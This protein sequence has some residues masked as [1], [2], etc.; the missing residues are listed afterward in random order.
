MPFFP[1]PLVRRVGDRLR[2]PTPVPRRFCTEP[3]SLARS[4]YTAGAFHADS[5]SVPQRRALADPVAPIIHS[6]AP[7]TPSKL[8]RL[9]EQIGGHFA[10]L[11]L[12][13]IAVGDWR[14]AEAVG[15]RVAAHATVF[16]LVL[17]SGTV[18]DYD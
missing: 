6:S 10:F 1:R 12:A 2:H 15:E 11:T 7:S 17:R 5:V 16:G 14:S 13:V 9:A 3:C 8:I 18:T 4:A